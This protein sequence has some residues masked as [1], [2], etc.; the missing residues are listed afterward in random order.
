MDKKGLRLSGYKITGDEHFMRALYPI[1]HELDI[2]MEDLYHL[3]LKG[4]QS[5]VKKFIRL[6]EKYP[7]VPALKNFLSVLY[8]NM[9]KMEKSY[10]VNHWIIAEHPEYLFG[11]LN[12]A[13]EFY[14]KEEFD[15][16]PEVLGE[17]MELKSLYP[18]RDTFH[19]IEASGFFKIATLYF[20]AI[21]ALEQAEIRLDVLKEIV[22]DSEELKTA[23]ESFDKAKARIAFAKAQEEAIEVTVSKTILT[24]VENPPEFI[25]KEIELLYENDFSIGNDIITKILELP[26]QSLILDLNKVL[27]DSIIRYHHFKT[28]ADNE[29]FSDKNFSFVIHALLLLSEI[30]AA[31]SLENIFEVLRQEED[32]I[33]LFIGDI[34]TEYMWLVFYKTAASNL[35]ACKKFMFEP[36]IYSFCKSSVSEMANQIVLH[37]S[38]R[39]D[40]IVEWY[41]DIFR[42][43]LN[44]SSNNNV[45][46]SNLLGMLVND[47]LDFK[48]VEL[49]P[50]IEKLYEEEIVDL[51]ACGDI[52][53]V[54]KHLNEDDSEDYKRDIVSIFNIYEEINSW[55]NSDNTDD[56]NQDENTDPPGDIKPANTGKKPGRNDP[57]PCGS[58]KKYKKCCMNK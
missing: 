25:H 28:K 3:A 44:S 7:K 50:E 42:F 11:K 23:E 33:E 1:P 49:M 51:F 4:R 13:A 22:P 35:D 26:R 43:F 17:R 15:K 39:R 57:C 30:E 10:E 6:I 36:G 27:K 40:E 41:R 34:L 2:Q 20:C 56:Y 54:R 48:G 29:G 8:S 14:F 12:M 16:I 5:A 18:K 9:G 31:G 19:V 32:L 24:N 38:E 52:D 47:V 55:G 53:A 58:G 45:I 37:Q 46:D 21:G